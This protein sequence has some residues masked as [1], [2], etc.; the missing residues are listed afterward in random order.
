[1]AV[2]AESPDDRA[3]VFRSYFSRLPVTGQR[4][5]RPPILEPGNAHPSDVVGRYHAA[6]DVGDTEAIVGTYA[7]NGY[8]REPIGPRYTR[9]G[10]PELRSFFNTCYSAGRGIRLEQCAMTD[11]GLRCALEYTCVR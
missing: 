9:R 10:T 8:F 11:D 3:V 4:H 7:A 1:V 5:V 2:V 6:L